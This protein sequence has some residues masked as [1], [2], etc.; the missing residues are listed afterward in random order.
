MR[1]LFFTL[2]GF[3]PYWDYKPTNAFNTDSPGV[4]TSDKIIENLNTINKIHLKCDVFVG[5][6]VKGVWQPILFSI[7]T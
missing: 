5:S 7:F 6:V 4:I 2:L 3:T 1:N